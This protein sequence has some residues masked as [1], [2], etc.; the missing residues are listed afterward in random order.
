MQSRFVT[1]RYSKMLRS[2]IL[3]YTGMKFDSVAVTVVFICLRLTKQQDWMQGNLEED[4]H[5]Q[6]NICSL[7]NVDH[8]I[9]PHPV[10]SSAASRKLAHLFPGGYPLSLWFFSIIQWLRGVSFRTNKSRAVVPSIIHQ[11]KNWDRLYTSQQ[12]TRKLNTDWVYVYSTWLS[13]VAVL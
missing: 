1:Y 2:S 6:H 7:C 4:M 3:F 5:N 9:S 12:G 11:R 13:C 10:W 8:P